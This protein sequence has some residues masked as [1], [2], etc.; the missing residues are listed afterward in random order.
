MSA[1]AYINNLGGG[2]GA[3]TVS[4]SLVVLVR[5][6]WLLYLE[7]NIHII[8]QHLSGELTQ[9]ADAQPRIWRDRTDWKQTGLS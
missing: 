2:G 6:L 8:A 7:R 3:G 4:P 1:V 9:K 5:E